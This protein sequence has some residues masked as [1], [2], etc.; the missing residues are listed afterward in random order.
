MAKPEY[1]DNNAAELVRLIKDGAVFIREVGAANVPTGT[2]WTPT[3]ADGQIGYYSEDGYTLTPNPGDTTEINAHNGDPVVAETA[4]GFWAYAF[5]ALESGTT[6]GAAYFDIA[7]EDIGEDGS[8]TI[9]AASNS[10]RYDL[11]VVGLDQHENLIVAHVPNAQISE[12][13]ALTFNTSTLLA[14]GMT[15][16]TFKGATATPY[17]IKA[18]GLIQDGTGDGEGEGGEGG[19]GEETE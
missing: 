5:S 10:K 8:I 17:H 12:K 6:V 18:W 7:P 9:N 15:F 14:Y 19:E 3:P 13:E 11:V 2:E 1:L 4:P 16:R